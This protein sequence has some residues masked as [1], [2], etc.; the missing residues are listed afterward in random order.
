MRYATRSRFE[1]FVP[2][3]LLTGERSSLPLLLQAELDEV[4][5]LRS[6]MDP[7]PF[8][9]TELMP[10]SKVYRYAS[11]CLSVS[12]RILCAPTAH[13]VALSLFNSIGVRHLPVLNRKHHLVGM[14]TRKDLQVALTTLNAHIS[15]VFCLLHIITFAFLSG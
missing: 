9:A 6:Y 7:S 8:T 10:L 2:H 12:V 15:S 3:S 14:I 4:L 11:V 1:P 5:D 13:A